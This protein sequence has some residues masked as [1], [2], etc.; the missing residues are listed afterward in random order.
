[1]LSGILLSITASVL[2]GALYYYALLLHPLQAMEILSWRM[3]LGLP[4]LT[5]LIWRLQAVPAMR[6]WFSRL[7]QQP[8]LIGG[9]LLSASLLGLQ[10]GLFMW[11]PLHGQAMNVSLGYF[12]LPLSLVLTGRFVYG[13]R[14]STM[15]RLAV[16]LAAIGVA[17]ALWQ[18]GGLHWSTLLVQL[19]VPYFMLHRRMRVSGLPAIWTE[20]LILLPL[21]IWW[22]SD[23]RIVQQIAQRP[24]LWL[25]LPLLGLMSGIALGSYLMASQRLPLGLFGLLGYLEPALLF[26]VSLLVGERMGAG[27]LWTYGPIWL[28]LLM[29][30]LEG[31]RRWRAQPAGG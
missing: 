7:R 12:L 25:L 30:G 20:T 4:V 24:E 1:M 3:V 8:L 16:L 29:L 11:A 15:Q 13:E 19:Y 10:M 28:A 2:F 5:L 9:M 31:L 18:S 23:G 6:A 14:L 22:L 17:H 26:V 27:A 21:A